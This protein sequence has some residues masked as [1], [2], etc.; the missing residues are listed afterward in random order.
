MGVAGGAAAGG[1]MF[2]EGEDTRAAEGV[3]PGACGI[4][5]VLRVAAPA[6]LAEGVL[7]LGMVVEI[8]DG[9]E[10]GVATEVAKELSGESGGLSDLHGCSG[11]AELF[12]GG[13]SGGEVLGAGD[14][15]AFL[16]DRDD[17]IVVVKRS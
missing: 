14:S 10:V 12:C 8:E 13:E 5:D 4:N 3:V 7:E 9:G 16:I 6:A 2:A 11:S 15:P 17:E 1:E